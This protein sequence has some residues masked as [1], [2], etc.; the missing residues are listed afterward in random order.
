MAATVDAVSEALLTGRA[1]LHPAASLTHRTAH[2]LFSPAVDGDERQVLPGPVAV[3][4]WT[5]TALPP[6]LLTAGQQVLER[7][8]GGPVLGR[9]LP[10]ADAAAAFHLPVS[11]DPAGAELRPALPELSTAAD[12]PGPLLTPDVP[13]VRVRLAIPPVFH[14]LLVQGDSGGLAAHLVETAEEILAGA[15]GTARRDWAAV[16]AVSAQAAREAGAFFAG[17]CRLDV[18]GREST[19]T[20]VATVTPADGAASLADACPHA[21]IREVRLPCGPAVLLVE[22][23]TTPVPAV[24]SADG[25]RRLIG[26]STVLALIPLPDRTQV[27]AVQLST[28]YE[29]DWELY[30]GAFADLLHGIAIAWD[31]VAAEPTPPP[32][33]EPAPAPVAPPAP[34]T[35]VAPPPAAPPTPPT[36]PAPPVALDPFGTVTRSSAPAAPDPHRP[37]APTM[38]T[39]TAATPTATPTPTSAKPG[40]GTP[41]HVPPA[42]WDPWG[43]PPATTTTAAEET[44]EEEEPE[45]PKGTPVHIPP[46]DWDPWA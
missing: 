34:P 5:S 36:P 25:R 23:R 21:E 37:P 2:D 44:P 26:T 1:W 42:D 14:P 40:K 13:G 28:P 15:R 4:G 10:A 38:T 43:G 6:S 9:E 45:T 29:Q 46:A 33:P 39:T 7:L 32:A 16:T 3:V 31:G 27:L 22:A 12:R 8:G 41:V 19:A 17:V 24:L 30:A 18:G 20:L 11:A 35:P